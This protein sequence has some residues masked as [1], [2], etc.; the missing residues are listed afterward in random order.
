MSW[1]ASL[2][3]FLAGMAVSLVPH[4]HWHR[5]P[6]AIPVETGAFASGVA[7]MLAGAAVGIPGFLDHAHATTSLG[8]D[9][10]LHK[11]FTDPN[12]GYSQGIAQG[13]SGLSIFT[14]LFV[15]PRGWLTLYLICT[16]TLRGIAAWVDDPFGDPSLT[17]IDLAL[18]RIAERRRV[19]RAIAQR[20]V[21]EGPEL[22]D[23]LVTPVAAGIPGCDFVIVASRRKAGWES[24]V[25][26]FTADGCY[27]LGEPAER[28]INGRLR[29][30]YPMSEHR[31]FEAI[32]K[33]VRYD[34]PAKPA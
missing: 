30:L 6:A 25:A 14:F 34:L 13:F 23:R 22:A 26:V 1:L 15:T 8:L 20:E 32:R 12:A 11:A 18:S 28:T 21:L 24:G 17:G 27:R 16:G 7:T 9:A 29:T 19:R 33:S 5:F 3:R 10:M 2:G 4:R 31:D